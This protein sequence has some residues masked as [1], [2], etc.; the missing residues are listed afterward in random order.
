AI[1]VASDTYDVANGDIGPTR[2][3]YRM[4]GTGASIYGGSAAAT[5]GVSSG[6]VAIIIGGLFMLG[7]RSYDS[8][9]ETKSHYNALEKTE[10][11]R[12]HYERNRVRSWGDFFH[13]I[14]SFSLPDL[15]NGFS[16]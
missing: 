12:Y 14:N 11:G 8:I 10:S 7:E 1:S 9:Q 4:V 16:Y 6:G 13:T 3:S 5:A 15:R 2:Y